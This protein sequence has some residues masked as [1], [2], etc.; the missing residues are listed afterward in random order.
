MFV[1]A[2][3]AKLCGVDAKSVKDFGYRFYI[4]YVPEDDLK[5]LLEINEIRPE[6]PADITVH[7]KALWSWM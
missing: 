7:P 5:M 6:P 2:N 3:I 1:S 4:D